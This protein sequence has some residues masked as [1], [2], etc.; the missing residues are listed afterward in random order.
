MLND[1]YKSSLRIRAVELLVHLGWE[2]EEREQQQIILLDID[3][4]FNQPPQA[5][6]S[7]DLADTFCYAELITFLRKHISNQ[8][9]KL[10]EHLTKEIYTLIKT[11]IKNAR[12][13]INLT[14]HPNVEG[15]TGGV[16]FSYGDM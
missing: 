2:D 11:Q 16:T 8:Y 13:K 6:V 9:F 7:D 4:K 10:V 5:C 12:I 15:L 3:V 14:K 1:D